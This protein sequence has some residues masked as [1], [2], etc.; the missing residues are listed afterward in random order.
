MSALDTKVTITFNPMVAWTGAH[1]SGCQAVG[2]RIG[3]YETEVRVD[4]LTVAELIAM[5]ANPDEGT[6]RV[7]ACLKPTLV[8]VKKEHVRRCFCPDDCNCHYPWRPNLCGCRG[9]DK[10]EK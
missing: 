1:I 7:H 3:L 10:K 2:R 8:A 4:R 6:F 9:H 5:Q